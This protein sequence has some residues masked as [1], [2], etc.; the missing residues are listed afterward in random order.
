MNSAEPNNLVKE[1]KEV[2]LTS[3]PRDSVSLLARWKWFSFV[4]HL[5]WATFPFP[6]S[7]WN[8]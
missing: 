4:H 6:G 2:D 7:I 8:Y 1:P 5:H 3:P